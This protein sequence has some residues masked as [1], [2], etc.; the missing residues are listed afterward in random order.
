MTAEQQ[1]PAA[2]PLPPTR[3][4]TEAEVDDVVALLRPHR[5][6]LI[7]HGRRKTAGKSDHAQPA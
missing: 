5:Q 6:L 2:P 3:R 7:D 4:L 1:P